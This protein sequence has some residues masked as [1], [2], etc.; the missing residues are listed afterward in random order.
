M[1]I[2]Y[3]ARVSPNAPSTEVFSEEEIEALYIRVKK[4]PPPVDKPATLREAVQMIG[5]LGGHLGRTSDG[6]AGITVMWRGL[7]RLYEDVEM[8]R[9]H[10]VVLSAGNT[11]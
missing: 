9:A 10:R 5:S 4:I 2:T 1:H 3:L 6:D 11:S 8:L 7:M